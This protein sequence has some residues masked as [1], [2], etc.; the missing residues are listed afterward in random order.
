MNTATDAM[1]VEFDRRGCVKM[2]QMGGHLDPA[3][4]GTTALRATVVGVS[5]RLPKVSDNGC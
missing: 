3:V 2:V 5:A 1:E 4:L